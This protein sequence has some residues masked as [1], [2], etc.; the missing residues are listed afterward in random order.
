INLV[1][2]TLG[3]ERLGAGDEVL[4]TAMEHH[5]NIVPWQLACAA[6]GARLVP[7]PIDERGQLDLDAFDR[8]L[9]ERT[10][11]VGLVQV[12]NALGTVNPVAELTAKAHAAGA[13][14][15]VDGA[16]AVPH[17]PVDVQALGCDFYAFSGH[18]MFAPT[19]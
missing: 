4:I 14:V 8:L 18:K 16:Q 19:G 13:V 3:R 5:S 6:A 11:I 9:S 7:V 17:I 10:K 15:L 2:A 12:S 1:A